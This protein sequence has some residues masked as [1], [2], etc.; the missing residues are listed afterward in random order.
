MQ[1]MFFPECVIAPPAPPIHNERDPQAFGIRSGR[2]RAT[3]ARGHP[4]P[5]AV[6]SYR[7]VHVRQVKM[8]VDIQAG[9]LANKQHIESGEQRLRRF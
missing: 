3:S 2:C 9:L 6:F 5:L 7:P 1:T 8:F 4:L